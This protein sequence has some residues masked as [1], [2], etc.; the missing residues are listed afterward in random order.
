MKRSVLNALAVLAIAGGVALVVTIVVKQSP[1]L[2]RAPFEA[3]L[4]EPPPPPPP[5]PPSSGPTTCDDTSVSFPLTA[6]AQ[7]TA[8]QPDDTEPPSLIDQARERAKKN[9]KDQLSSMC[10]GDG[11]CDNGCV[12]VGQPTPTLSAINCPNSLPGNPG[13]PGCRVTEST[14]TYP[15]SITVECTCS[16]TCTLVQECEF[17]DCLDPAVTCFSCKDTDGDGSKECWRYYNSPSPPPP[18]Y[19]DLAQCMKDCPDPIESCINETDDDGD[20]LV[21]CADTAACP[22]GTGCAAGGDAGVCHGGSCVT[23]ENCTTAIDD[24]G[25]TLLNCLD[26]TDCP[27]GASCGTG[28]TCQGGLCKGSTTPPLPPPLQQLCKIKC[29]RTPGL[30]LLWKKILKPG[31]LQHDC[32]QYS[33]TSKGACSAVVGS[34]CDQEGAEGF[35]TPS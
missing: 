30:L 35:C 31:T 25:D 23:T 4:P 13:E 19:F 9:A 17:P 22:E 34:P 32:G 16:A 28:M 27:E 11:V 33:G 14:A 15:R 3:W 21:D 26:T 5:P 8:K 24:D 29:E 6:T 12:E 7:G 18:L 20:G 10:A 2:P 1:P